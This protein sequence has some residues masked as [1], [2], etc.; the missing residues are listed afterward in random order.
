[1]NMYMWVW[2]QIDGLQLRVVIE[3]HSVIYT[4]KCRTQSMGIAGF[5]KIR[6]LLLLA[7]S[8]FFFCVG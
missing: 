5:T 2:F 6:N 7:F 4:L 8:K 3:T 1:M